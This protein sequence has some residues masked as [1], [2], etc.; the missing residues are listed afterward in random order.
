MATL[1]FDPEGPVRNGSDEVDFNSVLMDCELE[2][3][4]GMAC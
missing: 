1:D 4:S 3:G 2:Y